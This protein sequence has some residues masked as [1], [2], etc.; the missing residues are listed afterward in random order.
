[1]S[2]HVG[3]WASWHLGSWASSLLSVHQSRTTL[4]L[5]NEIK[6]MSQNSNEIAKKW[7]KNLAWEAVIR[8]QKSCGK[9]FEHFGYRE[10]FSLEEYNK[11]SLDAWV[12]RTGCVD[13]V[14]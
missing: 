4:Y 1:M 14:W 5:S 8:I 7:S 10:I 13:C 9:V 2:G 11:G 3:F 6:Q 12:E